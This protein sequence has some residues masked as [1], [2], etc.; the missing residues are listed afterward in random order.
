MVKSYANNITSFLICNDVIHQEESNIYTYGFEILI[1]FIINLIII[2]TIGII[3]NKFIHTVLFL[4]F[5]CPIRQ[6]SGGYHAENHSKCILVFSFIYLINII[7]LNLFMYNISNILVIAITLVS[8]IGII[9]LSP[10][11]HRHNPLS[12]LEIK[13]YRNIVTVLVSIA[14]LLVILGIRNINTYEYTLFISSAICWIFIML[15]LGVLK[16]KGELK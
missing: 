11:E 1:A 13:K 14:I 4:L 16:G 10:L 9:I 5:Y 7:I 6:F 15:N 2:F 12:K 8:S 3:S